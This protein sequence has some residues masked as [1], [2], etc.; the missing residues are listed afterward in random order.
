MSVV[1]EIVFFFITYTVYM[2]YRRLGLKHEPDITTWTSDKRGNET[3]KQNVKPNPQSTFN[4]LR[5]TYLS[6]VAVK[7]TFGQF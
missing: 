2:R 1:P 7:K 5:H 3:Y 6:I 4:H